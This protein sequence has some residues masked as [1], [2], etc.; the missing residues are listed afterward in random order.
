MPAARMRS[1]CGRCRS[2][3]VGIAMQMIRVRRAILRD[4]SRCR[5]KYASKCWHAPSQRRRSWGSN[6]QVTGIGNLRTRRRGRNP[7]RRWSLV[8]LQH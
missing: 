7:R 3:S 6:E 8:V 4:D 5:R 1:P 2:T